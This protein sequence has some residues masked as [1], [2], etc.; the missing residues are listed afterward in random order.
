MTAVEANNVFNIQ[1]DSSSDDSEDQTGNAEED[2]IDGST[3]QKKDSSRSDESTK[4]SPTESSSKHSE[5]GGQKSSSKE[6]A[7]STIKLFSEKEDKVLLRAINQ[8]KEDVPKLAKKLGR[9]YQSVRKR[10]K[11][12]KTGNPLNTKKSFTAEEDKILLEAIREGKE[13]DVV[14]L[15]ETLDRN[16]ASVIT[17]IKKLKLTGEGRA[18]LKLYTLEEDM[19][20]LDAAVEQY[21]KV[22]SLKDTN[23]SSA[24]TKSLSQDLKREERSISKRWEH[25]LKVWLRGYYSNTL[26]KE[27]RLLLA[28]LLVEKFETILSIDWDQVTGYKEFSGYT[29]SSLRKLLHLDLMPVTVRHFN[30]PTSS[31][32]L[33]QI[34]EVARIKFSDGKKVPDKLRK[35]QDDII[36]Y[37]E[38]LC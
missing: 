17:R 6:K 34:A 15:A 8:G 14:R 4:P 2:S 22:K 11:K 16:Q 18:A 9:H 10:I 1:S 12:L 29:M 19:V 7:R 24:T 3:S 23:L 37:W 33:K 27:V 32:T 28:N 31:L 20:I 26:N 21:R 36:K 5:A 25:H 13:G 30:V 38:G 35:R